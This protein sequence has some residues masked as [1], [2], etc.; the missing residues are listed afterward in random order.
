[1]VFENNFIYVKY[2]LLSAAFISA[3]YTHYL[4]DSRIKENSSGLLNAL[5]FSFLSVFLEFISIIIGLILFDIN[6]VIKIVHI[7]SLLF[8][9]LSLFLVLL[10][11]IKTYTNLFY[12][13]SHHVFKYLPLVKSVSGYF[14]KNKFSLVGAKKR[15]PNTVLHRQTNHLS[16]KEKIKFLEGGSFLIKS[17]NIQD[18][19]KLA[20][21][22]I[23]E[24]LENGEAITYVTCYKNAHIIW[25]EINDICKINEKHYTNIYFVD[26]FA[27][28]FGFGDNIIEDRNDELIR[29]GINV[30]QT[31][32]IT[33]LHSGISKAASIVKKKTKERSNSVK[34]V[35][36][37][38]IYDSLSFLSDYTST[39]QLKIFIVHMLAAEKGYGVLTFLLE[40]NIYND[41]ILPYI[42]GIVD[43][44]F[45]VDKDKV[46]R[47]K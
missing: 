21:D 17:N 26:S 22:F 12:L 23:M 43:V 29:L 8:F 39:E 13:R 24:G 2:Y 3:I 38:V 46:T 9:L 32:G 31:K 14:E 33:G 18:S 40:Q 6:S 27:K 36:M 44:I 11:F 34:R 4:K 30:I 25:E 19:R 10:V 15:D 20:M 28:N 47:E 45:L 5:I 41:I 35:P 7:L 1:M 16:K 37:R 42:S